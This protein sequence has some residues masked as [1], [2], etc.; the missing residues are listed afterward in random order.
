MGDLQI[1][2][3]IIFAAIAAFLFYRLRNVLGKR[4]GR[5]PQ[6]PTQTILETKNTTKKDEAKE[7]PDLEESISKLRKAY[8]ALDDFDHKKFIEGAKLAY[9][10]IINSFNSGDKKTLKNLLTA[11]VY[12]A[13]EH[14]INDKNNIPNSQFFSLN[15]E[16]IE[17]VFIDK[18]HISVSILF[19]S[20]QFKNNDEST[21]TKKQ[22][23]E[24][25]SNP[26][27]RNRISS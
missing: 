16:K 2:D 12:K 10:T 1:Y 24:A 19:F 13:F 22:F 4:T 27:C 9:E 5:E 8:E 25:M 20:E 7:I 11:E 15:I 26:Y 18:D 3:I 14:A 17:D 6:N 21:I 23:L